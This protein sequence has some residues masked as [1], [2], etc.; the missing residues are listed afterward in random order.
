MFNPLIWLL[1]VAGL[2]AGMLGLLEAGRW[3]GVRRLAADPEGARVGVGAV[4]GAMFALMGLLIAF[5]FSGAAARLDERRRLIVEET[6]A[7]GTAYLRVDLLPENA[8]PALRSA[9]RRYLDSRLEIY[10]KVPDMEAVQAEL[11]KSAALQKEIWTLATQAAKRSDAL[12]QASIL[13]LPALNQMID[14][15]TTRMMATRIHP[16]AIVFVMLAAS[17]LVSSLLAGYAMAGAKRRH[18]L[19]VWAFAA[20]IALTL[21]VI[22]DLEFPRIGWI[23]VDSFDQALIDL[24]ASMGD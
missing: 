1:V 24:R 21:Y 18:W 16:P 3:I 8:Q 20:V 13:L 12:P 23:R 9:F 17:A 2:V 14:I 15:T 5:T 7:I 22:V 11:A 10:R 4:E 6:N 19:H